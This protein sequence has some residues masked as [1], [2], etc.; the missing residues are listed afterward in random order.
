MAK[1][2]DI[3]DTDDPVK[4]KAV[5]GIYELG[6]KELC[7]SRQGPPHGFFCESRYGQPLSRLEA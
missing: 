5:L 1:T 2:I 4:G 7:L 6:G 3:S